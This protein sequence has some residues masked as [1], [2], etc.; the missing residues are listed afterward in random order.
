MKPAAVGIILSD[1]KEKALFVKRRDTPIWVLIAGGIDEGEKPEDAVIREIKEESG[2]DTEVI[3]KVAEYTPICALGGETHFF[4]CRA[5]GGSIS[6]SDETL[7]VRF[8]SL[9]E[10]PQP[11]F[12]VHEIWLNEALENRPEV[13]KR[14]LHEVTWSRMILY[15]LKHP[16]QSF[17]F[18]LSY[19]GFPINS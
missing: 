14:K 2:I 13:I 15:L 8:F 3:R 16:I 19:F 4:E 11:F 18:L 17:R 1:D 7:D 10:L 5:I 6:T 9:K 12:F